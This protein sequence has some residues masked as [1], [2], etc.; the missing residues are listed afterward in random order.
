MRAFP[1]PVWSR[2]LSRNARQNDDDLV[3]IQNYSGHHRLRQI[4][5]EYLGVA[6]GVECGPDQV[7]IVTGAQAALDLVARILIDEGDWVWMEE[8][9]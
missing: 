7:I 6:R 2:L 5:A 4:I 1:F 8:S 9:G 3:A